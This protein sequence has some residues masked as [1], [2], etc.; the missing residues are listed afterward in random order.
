M[1]PWLRSAPWIVAATAILLGLLGVLHYRDA[2]H[3]LQ[4]RIAAA[5]AEQAERDRALSAELLDAQRRQ[6][7]TLHART[8]SQLKVVANEPVTH[9]CGPVMRAASHGVRQIL[10]GGAAPP[11]P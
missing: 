6:L 5:V 2:Y 3:A 4:A 8:I 10:G 9:D 7:E 11:R 1:T